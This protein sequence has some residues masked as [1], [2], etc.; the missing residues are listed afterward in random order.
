MIEEYKKGVLTKSDMNED[1]KNKYSPFYWAV[2]NEVAKVMMEIA[3]TLN[4]KFYMWLTD[5][6]YVDREHA[7]IGEKIL[8]K[9]KKNMQTKWG[10]YNVLYGL[11]N[12]ILDIE[13]ITKLPILQVLTYLAYSQDYSIKQR[14]KYDHL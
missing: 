10:W 2:I 12:S 1:Y 8:D 9:Y 14:N 13:K 4:D 3:N 5:C 11:S 7:G 6:V